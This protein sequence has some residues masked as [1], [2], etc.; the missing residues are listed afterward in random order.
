MLNFKEGCKA[1]DSLYR[2]VMQ[3]KD[4]ELMLIAEYAYLNQEREHA[5]DDQRGAE[6]SARHRGAFT[7]PLHPVRA[8]SPPG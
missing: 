7:L 4:C 1:A 5:E 8:K 3:S 2:A 6:A